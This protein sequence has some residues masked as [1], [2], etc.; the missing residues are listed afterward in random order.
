MSEKRLLALILAAFILLGCLYAIT[1]PVFEASDE[2]WHYPMIRH[3]ADGNPLP[4]QVFDPA[5]AGPWKQEASQPPLYYY[6]GAALT[7]WIDASDMESVRRLNPHVDN[8]VVTA[9]GNINLIVHDPALSPWRGALLAV[10]IVRLASVLM[11]AVTVFFTYHIARQVAPRR[12][13]IALGATALTAFTPMFLFISGAVNNDNLAIMLAT[14]ALFLMIRIV[15]EP[16]AAREASSNSFRPAPWLVLGSVI[17]LAALTKEGTLGLIP[18]LLGTAAIATWQARYGKPEREGDGEAHTIPG[19]LSYLIRG[20]LLRFIV[21]LLPILLIAGWWYY[22][23]I[24]LYGDWLGWSAF[25]AVLG[26]RAQPASL[27]QLWDERW[28]FLASYWGLFG[29]VNVPMAS[30][31]YTVLNGLLLLA[32]PGLVLASWMHFRRWRR[33]GDASA[34]QE[35]GNAMLRVLHRLFGFVAA[36]F[37]WVV[38]VLFSAAIIYGLINWATTTWSSQ[39]RLAFT[40]IATLSA[41]FAL[42]LFGWMPQRAAHVAAGLVASFFFV[43]ALVAPFAWIMPAYEPRNATPPVPLQPTEIM[44][45]DKMV[46]TGYA[47]LAS[48]DVNGALQPGEALDVYLRWRVLEPM[49]RDWSVFVH[50]NDPVVETPVAQRDMYPRGGLVATSFLQPGAEFVDRLRLQTPHTAPAPAEL[51]L[52]VGLYD[53]YSNQNERL[54]TATGGVAFLE[55]VSLAPADGEGRAVAET[56]FGRQLALSDYELA[57]R[58]VRPGETIALTTEWKALRQMDQDYTLFAQ[59]LEEGSTTRWAAIDL[60]VETSQWPAGE[61]QHIEMPLM[62]NAETPPGVYTLYIG[63]YTRDEQGS[64][65]RLQIVREGRITME[66]ALQLARIRVD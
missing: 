25:I 17:G 1:T 39:G 57:S 7:F 19:V 22:R 59:L 46:L 16:V 18:M 47:L 3:L 62:V 4:V 43:I 56:N 66:D 2:L 32:I 27:A 45:G 13:E 55:T 61:A 34:S 12:P 44:F 28:G 60:Q 8:G 6:L 52:V 23:N 10:R 58:R 38:C 15:R 64:F 54:P 5:Q 31:V 33:P 11:G 48:G 51:D 30:W 65:I 53:F 20:T 26:E 50:L 14:I 35:T 9:D 49:A 40:A 41:L 36:H 29:G 63:A 24:V 37:A 21:A 42:G